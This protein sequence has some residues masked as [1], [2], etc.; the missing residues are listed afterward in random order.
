MH[1]GSDPIRNMR[2]RVTLTVLHGAVLGVLLVMSCK[3][4]QTSQPAATGNFQRAVLFDAQSGR[5]LRD[6]TTGDTPSRLADMILTAAYSA[7]DFEWKPSEERGKLSLFAADGQE[8]RVVLFS[9]N[10]AIVIG[11]DLLHPRTVSLEKVRQL[12]AS[13]PGAATSPEATPAIAPAGST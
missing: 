6:I 2:P 10:R 1:P 11:Q 12:L 13:A 3:D 8:T 5:V 9:N 4:L 7:E